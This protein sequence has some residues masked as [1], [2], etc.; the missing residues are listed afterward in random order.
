MC[1][2]EAGIL[3]ASLDAVAPIITMFFL[4][5]YAFVN[6]ACALQSLL[7]SPSWRPRYKYYHWSLSATGVVLCIL[8]M[9][10]S[11]WVY[12]IVAMMSAGLI[13]YYIQVRLTNKIP[14]VSRP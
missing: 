5:C 10:V 12:A 3:I 13:Y 6:L 1:I 7:K 4:M 9:L 8:L 2:A 11:S 14:P